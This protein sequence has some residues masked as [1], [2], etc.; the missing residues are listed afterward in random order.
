MNQF[1]NDVAQKSMGPG[2]THMQYQHRYERDSFAA[3]SQAGNSALPDFAHRIHEERQQ[4]AFNFQ[5]RTSEDVNPKLG[6]PPNAPHPVLAR[7]IKLRL[8][9]LDI[10]SAHN[11][12]YDM[13][14]SVNIEFDMTKCGIDVQDL[15]V[16]PGA[17]KDP[18]PARHKNRL[19][20]SHLG[21]QVDLTQV[22]VEGGGEKKHELEVEVDAVRLREQ[23]LMLL[24]GRES[25]FEELVEGLLSNCSLLMRVGG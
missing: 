12:P 24:N 13:R 19:S 2:R 1:L 9:D 21:Y 18:Q 16:P 23:A 20:Y 3:L 14:L 22:T 6:I 4:R 7:I 11:A 25:A 8:A 5:L 10:L 17:D 15:V